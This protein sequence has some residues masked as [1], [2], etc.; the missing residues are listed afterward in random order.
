M[1]KFNPYFFLVVCVTLLL[2]SCEQDALVDPPPFEKKPAIMCLMTPQSNY[3]EASVAYT[4][5]YYGYS[6]RKRSLFQMQPW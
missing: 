3:I 2:G 6:E 1:R 5:P 4:K